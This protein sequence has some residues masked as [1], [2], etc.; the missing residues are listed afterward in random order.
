MTEEPGLV[1]HVPVDAMVLAFQDA[2]AEIREAY[3]LLQSAEDRLNAAFDSQSNGTFHVNADRNYN[4]TGEAASTEQIGAI[5]RRA[6]ALIVDKLGVRPMLS[7]AASKTLDEQIKNDPTENLPPITTE[8]L[9]VFVEGIA[10]N[11][12][13]YLAEM[14]DEVFSFLRPARS[15]YKRN[16][17]YEIPRRVVLS[18]CVERGYSNPFRPNYY[19]QQRLV[20]LENVFLMLDGKRRRASSHYGELGEAIIASANGVGETDYFEFRAYRNSNL[21]VTFKRLDLL[22]ELNIAAG[23]NRLRKPEAA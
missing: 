13:T 7:S 15:E 2:S 22:R 5:H 17:E 19:R 16:S 11:A 21:H 4:R 8:G 14:L 9:R 20:A 3:R 10:D 6:L 23:G 18:G 12:P 1:P